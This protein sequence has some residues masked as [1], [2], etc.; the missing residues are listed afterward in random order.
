MAMG[1]A[2]VWWP[3]SRSATLSAGAIRA[4]WPHR[5]VAAD[6]LRLRGNMLHRFLVFY[7]VFLLFV[8]SRIAYKT[9]WCGL[10]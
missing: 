1:P 6:G 4:L 7:T 3:I 8:Y 10:G 9:P 2:A 5:K